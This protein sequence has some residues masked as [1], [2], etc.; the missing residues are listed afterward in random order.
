MERLPTKETQ[1]MREVAVAAVNVHGDEAVVA[2]T[3][4]HAMKI[5]IESQVQ[6]R[7]TEI[8]HADVARVGIRHHQYGVMR[9][10]VNS[11]RLRTQED[12]MITMTRGMS[13]AAANAEHLE[14]KEIEDG[15]I[16]ECLLH[17]AV[18][19]IL[20]ISG[21]DEVGVDIGRREPDK[22][23]SGMTRG[24]PQQEVGLIMMMHGMEEVAVNVSCHDHR[25]LGIGANPETRTM[26]VVAITTGRAYEVAGLCSDH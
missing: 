19:K 26:E 14:M 15:V 12:S 4:L 18:G 16:R 9:V 6:E 22:I 23:G 25:V 1:D 5:D 21:E 10:G 24:R 3:L 7:E 20:T 17:G 13:E 2:S 11:E 8:C